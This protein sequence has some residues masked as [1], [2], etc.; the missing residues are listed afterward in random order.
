MIQ[1]FMVGSGAI[2]CELLKTLA[3]MGCS[4]DK[5]GGEVDMC[6]RSFIH[7]LFLFRNTL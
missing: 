4:L 5:F 7:F 6:T 3:M 1:L 2:G